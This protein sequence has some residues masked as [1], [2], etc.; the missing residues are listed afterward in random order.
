MAEGAPAPERAGY[1]YPLVRTNERKLPAYVGPVYL[2]DIDNT[3][4]MTEWSGLRDLIRIRFEAAIDKRPV[5]GAPEML[6]ALRRGTGGERKPIYFVSASP[7]TMREVLEKRMLLDGVE[8][9]GA[10]FRDLWTGIGR[11]H[12]RHVRDVYGYKVAALLL[13]RLEGPAEAREVLFG[14]DREHDPEVYVLYAR[15]C[16]GALRGQALEGV[17]NARGVRK[18]DVDYICALAKELPERDPVDRIVIRRVRPL[19]RSP[20]DEPGAPEPPPPFDASDERV[21]VVKDYAEAAAT[22]YARGNI[23][24]VGFSRIFSA[25]RG[26]SGRDARRELEQ[27]KPSLAAGAIDAAVAAF[28]RLPGVLRDRPEGAGPASESGPAALPSN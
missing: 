9:D 8:Q 24:A 26:E 1:R 10:T 16:A 6:Q 25:V 21:H 5:A 2:F 22:L 17:L 7:A 13:Y 27:A 18:P 28:D 3:Y 12:L 23:D 15:I 14:D 4:L 11:P 19:E 20:G